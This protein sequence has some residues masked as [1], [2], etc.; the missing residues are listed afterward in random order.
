MRT[1][2]KIGIDLLMTVLLLLLMAYQITGQELHEWFGA[3]MLVLFLLHNILNIRWYGNLFK[4]KYRLLRIVQTIVNLGVLITMLC[5]GFSGIVLSRHVFA[6][7]SIHG[8]MATARTM[9]L[10]ASYWGFVLMSVHLGLHWGMIPGMCRKLTGGRENLPVVTWILR[11]MAVLIAV[12]GLYLFGRRNIISYMFLRV[13]FVF[14]DYEQSAAVV[15]A[16]HIAMMGFWIVA[17]YYMSKGIG[18][19]SASKN[20]GK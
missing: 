16:E 15:F 2:I 1:K 8:P 5:L 4:G 18:R 19:I 10:A 11:G 6:M 20:S 3:G 12:Y 14:F 9:H 7:L 13:H 17:A